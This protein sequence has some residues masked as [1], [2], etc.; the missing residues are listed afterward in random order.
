MRKTLTI[1]AA[2]WALSACNGGS[3]TTPPLGPVVLTPA[4]AS[5]GCAPSNTTFTA[6]QSGFTGAFAASSADTTNETV[7]A[8]PGPN[9]FTVARR[10]VGRLA[11]E[12]G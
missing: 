12:R 1:L 6:A 11:V 10:N 8:G 3:N 9:Q 7:A 2:L 5:L 4:S